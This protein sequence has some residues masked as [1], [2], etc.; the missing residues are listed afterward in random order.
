M[1]KMMHKSGFTEAEVREYMT[2]AGLV[3][4]KMVHLPEPIVMVMKDGHEVERWIFF[5][6]GRKGKTNM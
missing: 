5:A 2:E 6:R 1:K 3:E 4:F